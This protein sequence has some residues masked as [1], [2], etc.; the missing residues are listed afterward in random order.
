M[1]DGAVSAAVLLLGVF[2]LWW[3]IPWFAR[4]R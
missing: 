1:A 2:G 3:C 4:T